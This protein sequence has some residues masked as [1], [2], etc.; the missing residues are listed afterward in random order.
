LINYAERVGSVTD[1]M[2]GENPGQ[3]TPAY[4]MSAML[5]QG[6]QVFNGIF[7]RVY[8]SQ[9]AEFRKLFKL[10][11]I[12]LDQEEYFTYQDS[13]N[14][15]L[16]TDYTADAKD[17]IPAADPNAFSSKE[18]IMKAQ[19]VREASMQVPGY[20][21]IKVEQRFL[22]AMDIP[23]ATEV[24]PLVPETDETGTETGSMTNG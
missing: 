10:N 3:N 19:A 13:E 16:R 9:R 21:P 14:K 24:F 15:A 18:K 23:D 20:D 7:K 5:E 22:E 12:Y 11:A 17:L 6:L 2:T 4:N 1:T 8:R